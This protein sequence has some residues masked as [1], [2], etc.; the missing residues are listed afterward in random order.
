MTTVADCV[1]MRD[2]YRALADI[3]T[4]LFDAE[5]HRPVEHEPLGYIHTGQS[6]LDASRGLHR[7]LTT[8]ADDAQHLGDR[9]F[10][11]THDMLLRVALPVTQL[12]RGELSEAHPLR[13]HYRALDDGYWRLLQAFDAG[14]Q[15]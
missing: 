1:D 15:P 3:D 10:E 5:Q 12:I 2:V 6:A 8:R 4:A 7:T 11:R 9:S 14:R 13:D